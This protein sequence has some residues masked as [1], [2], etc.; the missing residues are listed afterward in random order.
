MGNDGWFATGDVGMWV[1]GKLKIIDR[2]KNIFK[3]AQGEYIR[4]EYIE[5]VYKMSPYITNVFV[6]G[7]S[8]NTF[9]VG[10]V[11][12]D[13]EVITEW[14]KANGLNEIA[15]DYKALC[16]NAK[17]LNLIRVSMETVAKEEELT[18]FERVKRFVL[19]DE[20]FSVDNGLLT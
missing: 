2:K 3:L 17:V 11:V 4:P 14:A 16:A 10:I 20:D 13:F 7:D 15:E 9:L 5:N 18:G 12:P 6:Y 8:L 19:H 1:N